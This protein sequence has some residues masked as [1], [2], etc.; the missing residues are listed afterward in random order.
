MP[1]HAGSTYRAD[2]RK[3]RGHRMH[4]RTRLARLL[5][6]KGAGRDGKAW[7]RGAV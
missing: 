7:G 2:R 5:V 1:R 6:R 4:K 3:H